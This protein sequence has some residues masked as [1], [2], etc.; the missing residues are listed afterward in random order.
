M[1]AQRVLVIDDSQDIHD[2][3]AYWLGSEGLEVHLALT[4]ADGL[5][6]CSRLLPDLVLLDVDLP[7]MTGF[8]ICQR[9]KTDPRTAP[10]PVVFLTGASAVYAKVQG[11][12]LGAIDYVTKPFDA[13]ELRARVRAALR[14]KRYQDLLATRAQIDGLTSLWNRG[15]FDRRLDDELRAV[16]RYGRVVSIVLLDLDH[17]KRLNDTHGHP[18]GDRVLQSMGELLWRA[19]RDVDAPCRYGGEELVC[20]MTETPLDGAMVAARRIQAL[21]RELDLRRGGERVR[22][23][24]SLGVASTEALASE[25]LTAAALVELA[26][27]ALY[28]AKRQGRDC[29]CA[30]GQA[31]RTPERASNTPP[32]DG[33]VSALR[34]AGPE[35]CAR[36]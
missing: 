5:A 11:F 23:T 12:D 18:F 24:A 35:P 8:E 20:V 13:A 6:M 36:P 14:T 33:E 1:T 26:D 17:F 15:Y 19:V 31:G 29:I 25:H 34:E 16:S 3:L 9:L 30:A 32:R 4:A 10:I 2:L 21:V 7:H 27:R 22:I 28:E